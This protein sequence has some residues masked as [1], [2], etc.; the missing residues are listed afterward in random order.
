VTL[1]DLFS[2]KE[3]SDNMGD[4]GSGGDFFDTYFDSS[5]GEGEE[6][7]FKD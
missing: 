4:A 7:S 6:G 5:D 2:T 1:D 3:P